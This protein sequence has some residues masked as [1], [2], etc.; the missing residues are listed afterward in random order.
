MS[1]NATA[2]STA[3]DKRPRRVWLAVVVIAVYLL[4]AAGLGNVMD[5]FVSEDENPLGEFALSHYVPLGI[6]IVLLL[7]FLRW[8][9]WGKDVWQERPTPTLTPRRW[10]LIAIPVL[11]FLLPISQ[12]GDVPWAQRSIGF[13][14]VVALG[15]LMVGLGEELV[16]RG[17][18]LT[19]LRAR[20]G[21][22]VTMLVTSFGFAAAHIP[23]SILSG[24]P[25]V[26]ILFEV[27]G[28]ATVG[29]TYYWVRRVTGRLWVGV[30][31]HALTD[32][33][34]YLSAEV[35]LPSASI[36]TDHTSAADPLTGTV[37]IILLVLGAFGII[38]LIREDRRT[39]RNRASLTSPSA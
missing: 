30:I 9:G 10:W 1:A 26:G 15:T 37:Q 38:S 31:L 33:V 17:I 34:L 27:G 16:F 28:L 3:T 5:L 4:L 24:V 22:L 13:I 20:H 23:S 19:T 35:G 36:P 25:L 39:R 8:T 18:L 6:A 11:A 29:A 12:F 14:L 7:L 32:W 21:E 2:P